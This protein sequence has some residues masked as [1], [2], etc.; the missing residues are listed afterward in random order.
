MDAIASEAGVSKATVYKHWATRDALL[1]E[2][3]GA[4]TERIPEF[5]SGDPRSDLRDFLRHLAQSR[6]REELGRLWPRVIGY[7]VSNPEFA[8][9]LQHLFFT[10]RRE[11]IARILRYAVNKGQLRE[12]IDT[13]FAMDL[14]IG[15]LMHRRFV[16]PPRVPLE[17]A[18]RVTDY[19]WQVFGKS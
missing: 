7:A 12:D 17:M 14:L 5:E 9:A 10:P 2:V 19:F 13:E 3:I 8:K 15:P 4:M 16:D 1:I 11:Q 18:D 6:K